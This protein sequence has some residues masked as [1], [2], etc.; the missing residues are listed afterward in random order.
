MFEAQFSDAKVQRAK[1][2]AL[3]ERARAKAQQHAEELAKLRKGNRWD[4]FTDDELHTMLNAMVL[5]RGAFRQREQEQPPRPL[6]RH[7]SEQVEI[8]AT[9]RAE[10]EYVLKEREGK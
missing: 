6:P 3:L 5:S 1:K 2:A 9:I 8:V 4:K 10:L 7:W